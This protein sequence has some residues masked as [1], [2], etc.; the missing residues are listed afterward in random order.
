MYLD[1]REVDSANL[2]DKS[3]NLRFSRNFTSVKKA[4]FLDLTCDCNCVDDHLL[5]NPSEEAG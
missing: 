2:Q 5:V 1:I 3:S 4:G